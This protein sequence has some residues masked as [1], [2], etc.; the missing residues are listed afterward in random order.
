LS[1][2]DTQY[3]DYEGPVCRQHLPD[4]SPLRKRPAEDDPAFDYETEEYFSEDQDHG[5]DEPGYD[6]MGRLVEDFDGRR[7]RL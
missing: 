2:D 5:Q 1:A 3:D 4:W 6:N 7:R